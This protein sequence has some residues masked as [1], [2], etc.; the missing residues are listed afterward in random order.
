MDRRL[1]PAADPCADRAL[2]L[3]IRSVGK[4]RNS[5]AA[6]GALSGLVFGFGLEYPGPTR[7]QPE[8]ES[9]IIPVIAPH[10]VDWVRRSLD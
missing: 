7:I 6:K 8:A 9:R 5:G 10:L 3:S 4:G 1:S 2:I